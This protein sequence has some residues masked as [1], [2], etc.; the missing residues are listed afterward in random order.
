MN[1]LSFCVLILELKIHYMSSHWY[2]RM[3]SLQCMLPVEKD[4][5]MLLKFLQMPELMLIKPVP[6]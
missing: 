2:Y 4:M 1:S 5:L 6:R 3:V